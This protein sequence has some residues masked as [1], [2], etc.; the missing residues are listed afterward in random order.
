MARKEPGRPRRSRGVDLVQALRE[1]GRLLGGIC[2]SSMACTRQ[3]RERRARGRPGRHC[4]KKRKE[5]TGVRCQRA[6]RIVLFL[7]CPFFSP[8]ASCPCRCCRIWKIT[9]KS[10]Q[11]RWTENRKRTL[12]CHLFISMCNMH[13]DTPDGEQREGRASNFSCTGMGPQQTEKE[14][15]RS[16]VGTGSAKTEPGVYCC[17][18]RPEP[19]GFCFSFFLDH[20]ICGRGRERT[21]PGTREMRWNAAFY[22]SAWT[23]QIPGFY[24]SRHDDDYF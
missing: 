15:R 20:I 17:R 22:L 8:P 2:H 6:K 9:Q 10:I 19:C 11:T 7:S 16:T 23:R 14:T 12:S 13:H 18:C 1:I 24:F 3:R 21:R 5:N 4:L